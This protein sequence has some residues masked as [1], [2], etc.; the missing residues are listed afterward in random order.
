MHGCYSHRCDGNNLAK[1]IAVYYGMISM[2]DKYIGIIMDKLQ[3]LGMLDNT[4]V[5]F[6]TDHGHFFGQHGLIAKGPFHYE[7]MIRIPFIA[8]LPGE[9][10]GNTSSDALIS[11][12]DMAP[13]FLSIC[14]L[15][16]PRCM[17]GKNQQGVWTGEKTEIRDHVIVENRHQPKALNNKTYVGKRYKLTVYYNQE[18]GELFDLEADPKEINNLWNQPEFNNLKAELLLKMLH[19]EMDKEPVLMPRIW[20]A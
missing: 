2:M 13:T 5:V 9:I 18:Y 10:P 11:Q 8:S 1:D 17:T 14:N 15:K 19:A 4:L 12:A 3:G 7:D 20:F 16:I 6:T